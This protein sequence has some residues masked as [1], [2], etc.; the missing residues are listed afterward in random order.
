MVDLG[1]HLFLRAR[2]TK[3][4]LVA[5]QRRCFSLSR[6]FTLPCPS[7]GRT[8]TKRPVA[9]LENISVV[10]QTFKCCPCDAMHLVVSVLGLR[11]TRRAVNCHMCS[12]GQDG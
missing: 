8:C 3:C 7:F 1:L 2:H 6:V 5:R 11:T 10:A 9:V 4:F 12:K